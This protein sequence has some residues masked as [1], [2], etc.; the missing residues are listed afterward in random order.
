MVWASV[1]AARSCMGSTRKV[2]VLGTHIWHLAVWVVV[3][4]QSQTQRL[5]T[6]LRHNLTTMIQNVMKSVSISLEKRLLT[7]VDT[8]WPGVI[9]LFNCCDGFAQCS[10]Y[11]DPGFDINDSES[12]DEDVF[13][14]RPRNVSPDSTKPWD[15]YPLCSCT[16]SVIYLRWIFLSSVQAY[17]MFF[18]YEFPIQ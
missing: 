3:R 1:K 18:V 16:I 4:T 7:C 14:I 5:Q 2:A 8:I 9:W 12:S 13:L 11:K 17:I 6:C 10:C 15:N